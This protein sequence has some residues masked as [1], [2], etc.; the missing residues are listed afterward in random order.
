MAWGRH[1]ANTRAANYSVGMAVTL[2]D[3]C[4]SPDHYLHSFEG[5]VAVFVPMDRAAYHRSIFLDH[6]IS[7]AATGT[8]RVPVAGLSGDSKPISWI[9]HIAHCGSTLLARALDRPEAGLVLREPAA[10]RQIGIAPDSAKLAVVLAMLGKRYLPD[11]PTIV[12]A[13]VPV[14]FIL[15]D[16]VANAKPIRAIFMYCGLRDYLLA[17]LRSDG[18]RNWVR[19]VTD[20]FVAHMGN[21]PALTDAE[22]AAALWRAQLARFSEAIAKSPNARAMDSEI[23]FSDPGQAVEA[24]AHH[25]GA[26][27]TRDQIAATVSGPLFAT[28]AKRPDASFDNAAR[29]ARKAQLERTISAELEEAERWVEQAGGVIKL[30]RP[31]M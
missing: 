15:S 9:F 22:R 31:L 5:D 24:T 8:M 18:H 26:I 27:L 30:D 29:L 14:N 11:A 1:I 12:K 10:L 7:P 21:R 13:N 4:A 23:F 2:G 16:I 6:R 28:H 3:L 25:L 20:Q 17:V 19:Q